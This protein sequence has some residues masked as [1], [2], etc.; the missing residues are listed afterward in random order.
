MFSVGATILVIGAGVPAFATVRYDRNIGSHRDRSSE[1]HP[2]SRIAIEMPSV[3]SARGVD[4]TRGVYATATAAAVDDVHSKAVV[5]GQGETG[6][7]AV[8]GRTNACAVV[9]GLT[10]TGKT[11]VPIPPL[12][13]AGPAPPPPLTT[14]S[15]FTA[16]SRALPFTPMSVVF[17]DL[18]Y[19]IKLPKRSGGGTR[20][21]LQGVSGYALPGKM[22]ALMG[23]SGAGKVR[24]CMLKL[25]P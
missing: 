4:E 24:A 15:S 23:A 11:A 7:D 21:L 10:S 3:E 14:M 25:G 22:I 19:T 20:T 6:A 13:L 17:R 1:T 12:P 8:K 2:D 18:T 16:T 5:N 9:L